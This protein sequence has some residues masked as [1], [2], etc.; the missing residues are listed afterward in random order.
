[1]KPV[2]AAIFITV[3]LL[4][5]HFSFGQERSPLE[6]RWDITVTVNGQE[7]PNWLEVYHSGFNVLVGQ[8]VG[9]VGSARP[10][11]RVNY[12]NGNFS[13]QIPPQWE[14]TPGDIRMVGQ[15]QVD[16][17]SGMLFNSDGSQSS[18]KGVRAPAMR[19]SATPKWGKPVALFNGKNLD[20]WQ[21]TGSNQ[22]IVENGMLKNPNAGANL[23]TKQHFGDFKLHVEFRYPAGSNGGIYLRGRYEL[24][25]IDSKG[26][27]PARD[28]FGAIY[29]FITPSE[30]AAKNA[31]EWQTYDVTLTGR[32]IT[33][34]ANGKTIISN[35]EIPG[36]TGGAINSH[37]GE[38]GPI[39]LQ[40]DHGP[41]EFRNITITPAL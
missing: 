11:S 25:I 24:Q 17:I 31:G 14:S 35:Q 3:F 37:E 10:I 6:G 23:F 19:S 40:G 21:A 20:G 30:M 26:S 38:P 1:M 32:M 22:W 41:I 34:I 16:K 7:F 13:F 9:I 4:T 12:E 29:G 15:V 36:I 2:F 28:L 8:Y 18:F 5:A 33:V 27:A 39:Y